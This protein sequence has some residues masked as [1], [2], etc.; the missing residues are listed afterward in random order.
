[1]KRHSLPARAARKSAMMEAL[2]DLPPIVISDLVGI[3]P[4]TAAR[5]ARLAG[6]NWSDY[7]ATRQPAQRR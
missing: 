3:S 1:M 4:V 2:T 6:D 7:L 5:W